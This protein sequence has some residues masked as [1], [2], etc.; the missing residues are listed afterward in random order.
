MF[1]SLYFKETESDG[2]KFSILVKEPVE[3]GW[4]R[5]QV[6]SGGLKGTNFLCEL[7]KSHFWGVFYKIRIMITAPPSSQLSMTDQNTKDQT[8]SL[9]TA[10]ENLLI[11]NLRLDLC[12]ARFPS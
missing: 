4:L 10:A 6:K 7:S 11:A 12:W 5:V 2:S 3:K 8:A 1:V 9:P